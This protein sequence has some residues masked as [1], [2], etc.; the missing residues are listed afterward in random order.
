MSA[1]VDRVI[2]AT[3][4]ISCIVDAK[5]VMTVESIPHQTDCCAIVV[6]ERFMIVAV[7]FS[8]PEPS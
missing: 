5:D 8:V 7:E 4:I 3:D 6:C 1:W 2:V